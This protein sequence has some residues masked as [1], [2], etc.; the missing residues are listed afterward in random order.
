VRKSRAAGDAR[1]EHLARIEQAY[2]RLDRGELSTADVLDLAER[3]RAIFERAGDDFG[4]GRAWHCTAVVKAIYELRYADLEAATVH[5]RRHYERA[6]FTLGSVTFLQ[7]GAAYRGPMPVPEAIERCRSLL[8]EAGTP[9][10]Q[11]FILPML[12]A[13][14][15]MDGRFDEAR[16]HLEEARLA[17][18]EF[19]DTGTIVTSWAALAGEV[20]LLA[21]NPEHAEVILSTSCDALRAVGAGEWLATNSALL[22]EALYRQGRFAEA[23]D[24]S[25][26]A[27]AAAPPEHLT[28]KAVAWVVQAKALARLGSVAEAQALAAETVEVL[29]GAEA[30]DVLGEAYAAS[31]EVHALA[32]AS[33]EADRDWQRA[34]DAFERKGNVV[35]AARVRDLR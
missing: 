31:A 19:S 18:Q 9:V 5:I 17:R 15:A 29:S 2:P 3:G 33:A 24:A 28:S 4:L 32:G 10:W 25:E 8:V 12:A 13:L 20:E 26:T 34:V 35:S 14:E 1:V 23:L 30:L 22:G 16:A 11:S 7:A 21:G 27:L 6:G